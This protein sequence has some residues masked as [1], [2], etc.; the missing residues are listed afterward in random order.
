MLCLDE[1]LRDILACGRRVFR[2]R[3]RLVQPPEPFA[4]HCARLRRC[5]ATALLLTI[6]F[7]SAK[8]EVA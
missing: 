1:L 5:E 2:R 7:V 3:T 6:G 8:I 4:G